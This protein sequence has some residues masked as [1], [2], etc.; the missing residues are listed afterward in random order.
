LD[1]VDN[2]R[3]VRCHGEKSIRTLISS[4]DR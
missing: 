2:I 1:L 4:V 3:P